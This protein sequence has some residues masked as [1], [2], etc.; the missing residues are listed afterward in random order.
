[1]SIQLL[2]SGR[3]AEL[4]RRVEALPKEINE[5]RKRTVDVVDMNVHFTQIQA[6][7]I[8]IDEYVKRQRALLDQL[9][10][11]ANSNQFHGLTLQLIGEIIRAQR[12]W[13]FFRDKLDLRFSP[14]FKGP[15]W[16]ADTIAWNCYRPVLEQAIE[17][18]ILSKDQLREPPLTYLTAEFSAAT[19]ERGRRP[20]DGRDYVLGT[21]SLPIPVIELPWDHIVN[22]WEFLTIHHEVGHDLEADLQLRRA[23]QGALAEELQKVNVPSERITVWQAWQ[24]EVFADLVGLQ[25]GGPAFTEVLMNL[26][27]LPTDQVIHYNGNDPHPTHYVR[28]LMNAAYSRTLLPSDQAISGYAQKIEAQ[29]KELYGEQPVFQAYVADFPSVFHALMDTTLEPLKGKTVRE[30]MPFTAY[31][32]ERICA[33]TRY[34][35]TGRDAPEPLSIHPR[36][37]VS[38]ARLAVTEAQKQP[39]TLPETLASINL[40]TTELVHDNALPGLRAYEESA[41][42]ARF[43]AGFVDKMP[44]FD[45]PFG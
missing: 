45:K 19:W 4:R 16:L 43:I 22:P 37:C 24:G 39:G 25:L 26:L 30:L 1:M 12:A 44:I 40:R 11:A 42:H 41:R 17:V 35:L 21:A 28:I 15:L 10:Q 33:A 32:Q 2:L 27:L 14:T 6:L 5:W 23:L 18:G 34:L 31:D 13:D 38:A 36:H 7:E 8:L 3:C 9:Q 29:W 20:W